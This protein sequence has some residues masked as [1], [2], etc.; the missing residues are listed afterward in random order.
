MRGKAG[1]ICTIIVGV[2]TLGA[3]AAPPVS[4]SLHRRNE[5]L[6]ASE[7]AEYTAVALQ[8]YA[9]AAK[10]LVAALDDSTWTACLE[11]QPG[12][13]SLPPAIIIDLDETVLD[14]R[15]FQM[16]LIRNNLAFDE[17]HWNE[18]VREGRS[19]AIP[20]ALD[21][22]MEAERRDVT[23]FF[24][25]NRDHEVEP[26]TR[27]NLALLGL[28]LNSDMDTVLTKHE[29]PDW[30]R[31]K[32][33]RRRL[34]AESYRVLLLLGDD[35]DDFVGSPSESRDSRQATVLANRVMWGEKWFVLP[36]PLYGGWVTPTLKG[37]PAFK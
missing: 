11:Q 9:G 12:Y 32:T 26:P 17:S 14:N 3:C 15:P 20:G 28:P 5:T 2:A 23:V 36:N 16:R 35:L 27:K 10:K 24:V 30:T 7:S 1:T 18:W 8:T 25:T 34:I 29:Q 37:A 6:W 4:V 33:T 31:D 13:E 19:D 22:L 21:F